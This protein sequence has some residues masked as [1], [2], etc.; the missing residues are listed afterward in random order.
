MS[1]WL[2][3]LREFGFPT[4][5]CCAVGYMAFRLIN[6]METSAE[7][8]ERECAAERKAFRDT[9]DRQ[10]EL[11]DALNDRYREIYQIVIR[12]DGKLR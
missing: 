4:L 11:F 9:I 10:Y 12:I 1:Q 5:V 6:R 2:S 7:E 3:I 8:R